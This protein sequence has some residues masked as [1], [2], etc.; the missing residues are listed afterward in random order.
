MKREGIGRKLLL[1]LLTVVIAGCSATSGSAP[2]TS[3]ATT[4]GATSTTEA[5]TTTVPKTLYYLSLGDSVGMWNG[6]RSYPYL[7]AAKYRAAG[8]SQ[9]R[10]VD[11]SCS[12]ET[13]SSMISHSTC[14]HGG[15]QYRNA[16]GFLRTHRGAV[17]LVTIGIGGNDLVG[18]VN[19]AIAAACVTAGLKAVRSDLAVILPGLRRAAGS[20]VRFVGMNIYDPILG[21][22]LAPGA[23]R[24]LA[25]AAVA[26]VKLLNADMETSFAAA[27]IPVA[28]V[29]SAFD[30]NDMTRF[31]SS[32]WGRVPVAVD[33]A[34]RL[35]DIT[36]RAGSVE[37]F[38]DD[39]NSSGAVVIAHAFEKVIGTLHPPA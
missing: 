27:A 37:G 32:P 19:A 6:D 2:G 39:P 9:L 13:T 23:G 31:V 14:A 34:C 25:L 8:A 11:M 15:S 30:S 5:T 12:G 1:L 22:W 4:T 7:L 24:S 10:L 38:G 33:A 16:V 21:D 3:H 29:E 17:A 26:G 20:G 18:C 36:C 28:N 35:L